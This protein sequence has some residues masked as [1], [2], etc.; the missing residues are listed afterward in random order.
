MAIASE[1]ETKYIDRDLGI[2]KVTIKNL[3]ID[4]NMFIEVDKTMH[5]EMTNEGLVLIIKD[6]YIAD[7]MEETIWSKQ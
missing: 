5:V 7:I 3:M 6:E 4:N 1:I 2:V